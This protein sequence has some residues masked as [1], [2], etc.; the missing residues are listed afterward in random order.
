MNK[1]QTIEKIFNTLIESGKITTKPDIFG[2]DPQEDKVFTKR[3]EINKQLGSV[4][5]VCVTVTS[6]NILFND[7]TSDNMRINT[8]N[9]FEQ[10]C[11]LFAN[12]TPDNILEIVK[13]TIC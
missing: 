13:S 6:N 4:D 2:E 11:N 9:T 7:V 3:L 10:W 5:I 1:E 12:E 8:K